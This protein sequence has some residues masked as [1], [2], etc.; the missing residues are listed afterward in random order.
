M[1]SKSST[2]A[3]LLAVSDNL[4]DVL[5]ARHF[6]DYLLPKGFSKPAIIYQ[7][8]KS[9]IELESLQNP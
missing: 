3:E 7:D 2:E 9:A 1:N 8:N 6:I 5:W 4:P